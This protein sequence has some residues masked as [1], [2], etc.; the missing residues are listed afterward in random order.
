MAD[1]S[2]VAGLVVNV[3]IALGTVGAA[4]VALWLGLQARK[5][6]TVQEREYRQNLNRQ[7]LCIY[8]PARRHIDS[9]VEVVNASPEPITSVQVQVRGNVRAAD[10]SPQVAWAWSDESLIDAFPMIN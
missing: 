6:S 7:V 9:W 10:G 4:G 5:A 8:S 2:A 1:G 3:F